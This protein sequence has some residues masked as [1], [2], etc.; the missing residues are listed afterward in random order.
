MDQVTWVF[1]FGVYVGGLI[2][3]I[4]L[5]LTGGRKSSVFSWLIWPIVIL[6]VLIIDAR[7]AERKRNEQG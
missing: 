2:V 5:Y 4:S 1:L 3:S 6:A 7:E